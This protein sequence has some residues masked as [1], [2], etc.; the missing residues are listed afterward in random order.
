MNVLL[1]GGAGDLGTVLTP[2]LEARGDIPLRLD[3]VPPTDQR[4]VYLAGSILD[5]DG[6]TRCLAGVDRSRRKIT[7]PNLRCC[8]T[9]SMLEASWFVWEDRIVLVRGRFP[10]LIDTRPF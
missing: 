10:V 4:G 7:F 1:T 5:R 8:C 3:I 6:L 9:I 2:L